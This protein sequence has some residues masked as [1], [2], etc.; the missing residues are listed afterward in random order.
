MRT[1]R[2]IAEEMG[3]DYDRLS[4][5]ERELCD[6]FGKME[7]MI[8]FEGSGAELIHKVRRSTYRAR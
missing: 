7:G 5:R 6:I 1:G 3:L 8:P 2:E 4:K